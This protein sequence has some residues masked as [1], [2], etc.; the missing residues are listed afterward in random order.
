[1]TYKIPGLMIWKREIA[2]TLVCRQM[3]GLV[4]YLDYSGYIKSLNAIL[5]QKQGIEEDF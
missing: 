4:I 2:H 1:M 3:G 5:A